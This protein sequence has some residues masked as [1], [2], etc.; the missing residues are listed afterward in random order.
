MLPADIFMGYIINTSMGD[1]P[2][3]FATTTQAFEE[4]NLSHFLVRQGVAYKLNDGPVQ[5]DP[6]KGLV[7]MPVNESA[8]I[9]GFFVDLPRT[10]HC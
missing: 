8:A 4:L 10:E 9:S 6:A 3:Y 7:A 1:R 2:I 5:P